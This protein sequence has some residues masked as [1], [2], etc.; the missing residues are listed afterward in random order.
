MRLSSGS[1]RGVL[2]SDGAT[3]VLHLYA[4]RVNVVLG[5]YLVVS[6]AYFIYVMVVLPRKWFGCFELNLSSFTQ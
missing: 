3:C 4:T 1:S 5:P 2:P 6:K